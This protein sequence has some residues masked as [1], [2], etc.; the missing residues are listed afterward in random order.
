MVAPNPSPRRSAA[1]AWGVAGLPRLPDHLLDALV[2]IARNG[3]RLPRHAL[4][5]QSLTN[6]L[7]RHLIVGCGHDLVELT[8]LGLRVVASVGLERIRQQAAARRGRVP[9]DPRGRVRWAG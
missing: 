5:H 6:L 3:G 1:P 4:H 8:P 7:G 9:T 2:S